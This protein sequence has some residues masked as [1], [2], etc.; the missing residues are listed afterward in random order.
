[1]SF[2]VTDGSVA[3]EPGYL[4]SGDFL[5][6]GDLGRPDLLDE[7]AGG[8]D[9]RE[10]SARAMFASLRDRF[11]TLPDHL[12]VFP[13]HGAGSACGKSLGAV[14]STSVGYEK[15]FAWWAPFVAAGVEDGCVAQLLGGP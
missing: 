4:L 3:D 15:R 12:Q 13:G 1:L 8:E 10:D 9:T 14:P 5:F 7:V 6:A 11:V 2:L